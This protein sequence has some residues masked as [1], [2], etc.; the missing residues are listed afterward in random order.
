MNQP[1]VVCYGEIGVD[2]IVR[3]PHL[4]T[5]ELAAF[6]TS[7]SYHIGGAAANTAV[8]LAAW[9]V[10]VR[11]AGNALGDD[12][13][14]RRL[15]A[16]LSQHPALDLGGLEV[17]PG[18]ATPFCR[19]LVT[20]DAERTILVYWYPRTPKTPLTP[21]MLAGARCV[22]LDLYGGDER[23]AAAQAARAAGIQTVVN[24]VV[25]PDHPVL[26]LTDVAT[27]SAAYIRHQFPGIDVLE[28]ARRLQAVSGGVVVTTDGPRPVC[29]AGPAGQVFYVQ[30]PRVEPVDTTGAGD[31]FRA[32]LIYG[33]MQDWPL[34]QCARWAAAAGALKVTREGAARD[35][36]S[37]AE[38]S[39]LAAS[40]H[41]AA[42]H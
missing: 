4:P 19:I 22:A 38:V 32:G 18:A 33:L 36:P 27:N 14:G 28:H 9:G 1:G 34:E 8:W 23:L 17:R 25:T 24:D 39:A 20:P 37:L 7:E 16:W 11:L 15:L 2:N 13:L 21:G 26:P 3:L 42:E 35:V 12:D 41:A 40:L 6:P 29:V 10:P 5:P 31:A 30:P